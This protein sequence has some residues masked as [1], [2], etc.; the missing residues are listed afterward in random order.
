MAALT[1]PDEYFDALESIL[2][3]SEES[4]EE[5]RLA[6]ENVPVSIGEHILSE[7]VSAKIKTFPTDEVE[8]IVQTL[9][10]FS[11]LRDRVRVSTEEFVDDLVE[12]AEEQELADPDI[13]DDKRDLFRDRLISLLDSKALVTA[14]RARAVLVDHEHDLC[15]V[16]LFTD[17][18]PVF[19]SDE[20]T[21]ASGAVIV[22]TLKLSYHQNNRIKEFYVTMDTQDLDRLSRLI[23]RT[24]S[25]AEGLKAVVKVT[26]LSYIDVE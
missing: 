14:A 17:I 22:H 9:M 19:Q 2:E 1:I 8:D 4:I 3:A 12:A 5:L 13:F 21:T 16:D 20:D 11:F 26:N 23:E 10:S 24:K 7:D 25:K 18:R 15:D 6:L